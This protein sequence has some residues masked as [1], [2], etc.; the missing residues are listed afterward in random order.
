MTSRLR[1]LALGTAVLLIAG[2]PA[3]TGILGWF[4]LQDVARN[5]TR[6]LT[7][8]IPAISEVRGVAEELLADGS[9]AAEAGGKGG[10][11]GGEAEGADAGDGVPA[12]ADAGEVA[13]APAET[14]G[15]ETAPAAPATEP[16]PA[17]TPVP[18]PASAL[19]PESAPAT[20]AAGR[21]DA[22][23]PTGVGADECEGAGTDADA[24][25]GAAALETTLDAGAADTA[26]AAALGQL[27]RHRQASLERMAMSARQ[28]ATGCCDA[29]RIALRIA[30]QQADEP[31]RRFCN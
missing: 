9:E 21:A 1:S 6:V 27:G 31:G 3:A 14:P 20:T 2:L 19:A 5:Q 23:T 13:R 12:A 16:L 7:E 15:P 28:G 24:G 17:P 26:G 30:G 8:A 29:G 25:A 11:A 22:D 18:A 4:E 10:R